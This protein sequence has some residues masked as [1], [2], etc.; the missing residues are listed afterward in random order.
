MKDLAGNPVRLE[1]PPPCTAKHCHRRPALVLPL[2]SN[3]LRPSLVEVDEVRG[4]DCVLL[5]G[6][7]DA[8][9]HMRRKSTPCLRLLDSSHHHG[10]PT[11]QLCACNHP[12]RA[13]LG[14]RC[15]QSDNEIEHCVRHASEKPC[16]WHRAICCMRSHLGSMWEMALCHSM[17]C[18]SRKWARVWKIGE[19]EWE[20][21]CLRNLLSRRFLKNGPSCKKS[22]HFQ[23]Y[24]LE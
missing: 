18:Q 17:Q 2:A 9:H 8:G 1:S 6:L 5:V 3:L 21:Q 19:G 24:E 12:T 14:R 13:L 10:V 15:L 23:G 7:L 16:D 4:A 11:G 20:E 22:N